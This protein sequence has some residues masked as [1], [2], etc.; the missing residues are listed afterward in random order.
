MPPKSNAPKRKASVSASKDN[1]KTA[2]TNSS[3]DAPTSRGK[4]LCIATLITSYFMFFFCYAENVGEINGQ[5]VQT[6]RGQGGHAYQLE[7][8]L[9]PTKRVQDQSK[10][11]VDEGIPEDV[12]ENA[13]APQALGKTQSGGKGVSSV[14]YCY[15]L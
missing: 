15:W 7:K 6:N 3:G 9:N 11:K 12:P 14:L 4:G 13:M 10:G 1:N 8:A 5:T 2:R